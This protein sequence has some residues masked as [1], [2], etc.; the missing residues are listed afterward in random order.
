MRVK[1]GDDQQY[2]VYRGNDLG[3]TYTKEETVFRVWSPEAITVH[4]LL[5]DRGYKSKAY[6]KI[7]LEKDVNGTWITSVKEDLHGVYYTYEVELEHGTYEVVDP[8]AKA[9]GVNGERGMVVDLTNTNPDN[10]ETQSKPPFMKFNDAI[11]YESHVRDLTI[12]RSSGHHQPGTFVGLAETNTRSKEGLKTG[13]DHLVELGITHLH[14]LPVNDFKSINEAKLEKAQYNWGYN[15]LH[16][17]VLEGSYSTNPIDGE[18]RIIEFKTLVQTLHQQGIRLILDF[19]FI[20]QGKLED[21]HLE[22]LCPGYFYRVIDKKNKLY[23]LDTTKPMA[24]KFVIDTLIY[25]V[26]EYKVDGFSIDN[27]GFFDHETINQLRSALDSIDSTLLLYG[28]SLTES[29]PLYANQ[30]ITRN[31][32][33]HLPRVAIYNHDGNEG[34]K[35]SYI[36]NKQPGF[37]NGGVAMEESVKL[38]LTG[39]VPHPDV[40]YD[41]CLYAKEP[42]AN[43]PSQTINYVSRHNDFTLYDKILESTDGL[44][45]ETRLK[46]IKLASTLLLTAQG[47]PLIQG[48]DELLRTKNGDKLSGQSPDS[49]NQIVWN[50]KYDFEEIFNYYKGLIDLRKNHPA[51]RMSSKG[52]IHDHLSFIETPIS[53]TLGFH[54]KNHA[55]GDTYPDIVVLLN[56]N[57]TEVK[58]KLP[59]FGI[60]NVVVD[61]EQAGTEVIRQLT[62]EAVVVPELTPLVLYSNEKLAKEVTVVEQNK[63]SNKNLLM[64]AGAIGLY[65]LFRKRRRK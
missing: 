49:I 18:Q 61:G 4:L 31:D 41:A 26:E 32:I 24:R 6:E 27:L 56:A 47:I 9:C 65:L 14:L 23:T 45:L 40:D 7:A 52:L 17:Q 54:L 3:A 5:F 63:K 30:S 64:A 22:K 28:D 57:T 48:G 10:W 43:Q 51:F 53:N 58:F 60:W 13:L 19:A 59:H 33:A 11:I 21:A 35:G 62:D 2:P 36:H 34:V 37:V 50:N 15:P 12:H 44:D 46:M 38:L 8:Y 1:L 16:F 20:H 29:S 25:F 55:N 42:W 39:A